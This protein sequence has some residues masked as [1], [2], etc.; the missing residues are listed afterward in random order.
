LEDV[1][2]CVAR[3]SIPIRNQGLSVRSRIAREVAGVGSEAIVLHLKAQ[4]ARALHSSSASAEDVVRDHGIEWIRRYDAMATV[5]YG[6][7]NETGD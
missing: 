5:Y 4:T 1:E 7:I 2:E 3:R 6:V